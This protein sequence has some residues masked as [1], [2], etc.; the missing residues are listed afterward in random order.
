VKFKADESATKL[1]GGY[2][3]P[4]EIADLLL[5]WVLAIG[6]GRLL[7]PSCGDGVFLAGLARR[8]A[9]ASGASVTAFE[10]DPAEADK[11]RGA[12]AALP[13]SEVHAGDFLGWSAERLS[14]P[15]LFD[16]AVGNPPFIRYQYLDPA[17][18]E[19]AARVFR[20]FGLPFTRH[21]NAWVPFVIASLAL[22]R[23]GGRLAMVLPA[24]LLHVLHAQ[25]LRT[26]LAARCSRVL[27]LDPQELW[28]EGTLQGAVLVLAETR[29]TPPSPG[30]GVA[31]VQTRG[32]ALLR[33]EPDELFRAA[34]YTDG[35]TLTGKW[36]PALLSRRERELLDEAANR[37]AVRR[38]GELA[39]VDIGIVTGANKFFLVPDAVVERHGLEPWAFPMF[40]RSEHVPGVVYDEEVHAANRRA[41]LPGNFLRFS[42]G[43]APDLPESVRAYLAAGEAEGLPGR[44]KCRIRQPWYS[45][46]SVYATP[47]G[48]LKRSHHFPRLIRNRLGAFTT[49]T[50]YRLRPR[51]DPDALVASFV[52]S[53]TALCAELE[54]RHYGG[55][56][57][58]LVPSEIEK[59]LVPLAPGGEPELRDLDRAIRGGRPPGELLARRDAAVLAPAG[60][61]AGEAEELRGAWARLRA[62]RQRTDS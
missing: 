25:P 35:P 55:G 41:G 60:L 27:V 13:G 58:E 42:A 19:V 47:V 61:A 17:A 40:G 2:Y 8:G 20:A 57:L 29:T 53:L 22:L 34:A 28:F 48:M 18:Q 54:G 9:A 3:T 51:V 4:P 30:D 1:R 62:R 33:E 50:A 38:L 11:A 45:V 32:E 37:P 52:N 59:L 24:E 15:P 23:P 16:A 21:A 26:F 5:R 12:A 10:I 56:V 7:E 46:P 39:E 43:A 44:Y 49:D 14:G 31:I 6:P 36:M